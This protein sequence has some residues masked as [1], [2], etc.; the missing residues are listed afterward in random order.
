MLVGSAAIA[1]HFFV[2]SFLVHEKA[3]IRQPQEP[4]PGIVIVFPIEKPALVLVEATKQH[5]PKA[6]QHST[7]RQSDE[8]AVTVETPVKENPPP[9]PTGPQALDT[10]KPS[11][12]DIFAQARLDIRRIDRELRAES[13]TA[14]VQEDKT[15]ETRLGKGFAAAYVGRGQK[16]TQF[17]RSPDGIIY[18]K[19]TSGGKVR[20]TMN[21]G[22]TS[23]AA[24]LKSGGADPVRVNCPPA[25]YAW[26]SSPG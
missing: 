10:P 15:W 11:T 23:L 7:Q 22:A 20:C 14:S 4:A 16:L 18:S 6:R 5:V 3:K 1:L 9:L 12:G 13:P 8:L 2:F 26:K 24:A 19:T 21:A 17:Y 25:H